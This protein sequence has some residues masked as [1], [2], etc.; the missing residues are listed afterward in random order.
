M[1]N[2][3]EARSCHLV[4]AHWP[5]VFWEEVRGGGRSGGLDFFFRKLAIFEANDL[6]D[7]HLPPKSGRFE[8]TP[9]TTGD[10]SK[11][12]PMIECIRDL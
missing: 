4:A 1:L 5:L 12:F 10:D 8:E 11:Y 7:H 3:L 2:L 6:A 9:K